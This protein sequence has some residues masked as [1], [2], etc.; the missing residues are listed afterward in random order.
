MIYHIL[1]YLTGRNMM[2]W[3]LA[4]DCADQPLLIAIV[5]DGRSVSH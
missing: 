2:G 5:A 3:S 1:V 4:R